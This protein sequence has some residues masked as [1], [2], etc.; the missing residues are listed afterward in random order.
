MVSVV[1]FNLEGTLLASASSDSRVL[2]WKCQNEKWKKH[3][4]LVTSTFGIFALNWFPE[5]N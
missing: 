4:E 5:G 1:K 3:Q 2:I